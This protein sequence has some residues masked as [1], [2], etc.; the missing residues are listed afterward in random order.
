M[1]QQRKFSLFDWFTKPLGVL[2][3]LLGLFSVGW[4][5]YTYR[6]SH[7]ESPLVRVSPV[8]N[9]N[10]GTRFAIKP[11][12]EITVEVTNLGQ[13]TMQVKSITLFAGKRVRIIRAPS[14]EVLT[15]S[16]E[17]GGVFSRQIE[18]NYGKHPLLNEENDESLPEDFFVE[19]ETTRAVHR[20]HFQLSSLTITSTVPSH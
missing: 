13:R 17:P 3:F 11:H 10:E 8:L 12:G 1:E 15:V 6:E 19:V 18:W 16:L 7:E 5:V 2:G 9:V 20:R 14:K 4:Q